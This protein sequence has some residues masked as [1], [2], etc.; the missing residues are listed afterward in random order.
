M[1]TFATTISA[2]YRPQ[3]LALAE[4]LQRSQDAEW[5]LCVL[6]VDAVA[7]PNPPAPPG[8]R[9]IGLDALA[10]P[11]PQLMLHYFDAFEL[12]NVLKP[13]LVTH[14]LDN[15]RGKVVYLDCDIMA[16]GSFLPLWTRLD[17]TSLILTPHLTR[18]PGPEVTDAEELGIVDLGVFN[19]G[20]SG[21]R[22]TPATR[23]MLAWM[24]DRFPRLGFCSPKRR[25]F[26]DQKLLPLLTLYHPDD[27][28]IDRDPGLNIGYWN[29][30]E[31]ELQQTG[32]RWSARGQPVVFFHLSGFRLEQPDVPCVY[33]PPQRNADLLAAHPAYAGMLEAY[34]ALFRPEVAKITDVPAYGFGH[35]DGVRLTP[36][37]R[38]VLFEERDLRRTSPRLWVAWADDRARELK[39]RILRLF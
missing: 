9:W 17:A 29:V 38:Q 7:N 39:R 33:N 23:S 27:V 18:P 19:G 11:F 1:I 5:E 2:S 13:F 25:M 15:D 22:D 20:F 10:D 21:W 3:A 30:P 32:E 24:R 31:R 8:V 12:C 14:L 16:V 26:V 34:A 6:V 35:Y 36:R 28:T 4:S 37:I